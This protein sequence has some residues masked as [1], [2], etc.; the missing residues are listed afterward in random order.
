[1]SDA[2]SLPKLLKTESEIAAA[3]SDR[4]S[5]GEEIRASQ[6]HD[7]Q[8]YEGAARSFTTWDDW[9]QRYARKLWIGPAR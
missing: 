5:R 3:L 6:I 2:S 8:T 4:I 9:N 1:M 7:D